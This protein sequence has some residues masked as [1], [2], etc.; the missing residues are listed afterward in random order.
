MTQFHYLAWPDHGVPTTG[1][2]LLN[3]H[4]KVLRHTEGN[5]KPTLVH[6]RYLMMY[7]LFDHIILTNG[8]FAE[9]FYFVKIS[10]QLNTVVW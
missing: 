5:D 9:R 1:T 8:L 3:L 2:P 10:S 7:Y 6:C 4:Y